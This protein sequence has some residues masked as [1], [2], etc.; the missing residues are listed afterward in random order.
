MYMYTV[1]DDF[2]FVEASEIFT[3]LGANQ[4]FRLLVWKTESL[5]H[6]GLPDT[7]SALSQPLM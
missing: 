2:V 4:A 7:K 5:M 1:V 3:Q 6:K